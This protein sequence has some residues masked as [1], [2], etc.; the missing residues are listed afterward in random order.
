MFCHDPE[1]QWVLIPFPII[2]WEDIEYRQLGIYLHTHCCIGNLTRS[3]ALSLVRF[4]PH[5]PGLAKQFS[6]CVGRSTSFW[7]VVGGGGVVVGLWTFKMVYLV[8]TQYFLIQLQLIN[9][10]FFDSLINEKGV[11]NKKSVTMH[12]SIIIFS[13]F[14]HFQSFSVPSLRLFRTFF[15]HCWTEPC[16]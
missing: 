8:P 9:H 16:F 2:L 15:N 7:S 6:K 4:L 10:F 11:S 5:L 13:Y 12:S 14:T 3:A 1:H